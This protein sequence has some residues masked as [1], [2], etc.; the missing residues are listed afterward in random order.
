MSRSL[1][2]YFHV[3]KSGWKRG[4]NNNKK[5]IR[6]NQWEFQTNSF[7]KVHIYKNNLRPL[8]PTRV[9]LFNENNNKFVIVWSINIIFCKY[10]NKKFKINIFLKVIS[11]QY[12]ENLGSENLLQIHIS[13]IFIPQ[14]SLYILI[15]YLSTL[16]ISLQ[17]I[18]VHCWTGPPL[19]H[20]KLSGPSQSSSSLHHRSSG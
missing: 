1:S 20:A 13:F 18:A 2:N 5:Y 19:V 10:N 6:K 14:V 8:L 7:W 9:I 11:F 4:C 3:Y 15:N 16:R 12:L 17:A